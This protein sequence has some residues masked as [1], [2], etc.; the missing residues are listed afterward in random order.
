MSGSLTVERYTRGPAVGLRSAT[1]EEQLLSIAFGGKPIGTWLSVPAGGGPDWPQWCRRE[2]WRLEHLAYCHTLTLDTSR[3]LMVDSLAKLDALHASL[4][5]H[6]AMPE[7]LVPRRGMLMFPDWRPF[8]GRYAGIV[9]APYQVERRHDYVWYNTWD[10]A[11]ACV[12]DP[13]ALTHVSTTHQ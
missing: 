8:A 10:C 12:W 7:P 3:V 1:P 13:S 11:S 4:E 5:L 6:P 9:I 2:A